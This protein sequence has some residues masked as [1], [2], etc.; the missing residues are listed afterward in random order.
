MK[1]ELNWA[2]LVSEKMFENFDRR[3]TDLGEL[4]IS[5]TDVCLGK[6]VLFE[7]EAIEGS[8]FRL[9]S[10]FLFANGYNFLILCPI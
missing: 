10:E 3:W 6:L 8:H 9:D 4:K 5:V 1:F 7:G 2:K